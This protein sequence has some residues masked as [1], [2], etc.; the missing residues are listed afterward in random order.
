MMLTLLKN[1]QNNPMGQIYRQK[2]RFELT[3]NHKAVPRIISLT[4]KSKPTVPG[5][6]VRTP[7]D[8][9]M[10]F[11]NTHGIPA[12]SVPTGHSLENQ[13]SAVI[14]GRTT[15]KTMNMVYGKMLKALGNVIFADFILY[16]N[17]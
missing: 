5:A 11:H 15:I 2:G 8:G 7:V 17:S 4:A 10:G 9:F 16:N 13:C 12:V 6:M 3:K 1:D 14:K